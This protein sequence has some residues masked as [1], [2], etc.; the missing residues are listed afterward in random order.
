MSYM[1]GTFNKQSRRFAPP[2]QK[3]TEITSILKR[4]NSDQVMGSSSTNI[5]SCD[6]A[7]DQYSEDS[8]SQGGYSEKSEVSEEQGYGR[9]N[10]KD[11]NCYDSE[12]E[13]SDEDDYGVCIKNI[14]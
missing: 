4:R 13:E 3:K 10:S 11:K 5:A 14:T 12:E 2:V 1:T 8:T 7:Y 9:F 6:D